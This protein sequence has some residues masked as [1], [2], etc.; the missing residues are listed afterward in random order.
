MVLAVTEPTLSGLHDLER[1]VNLAEHFRVRALA[2]V[3]KF[4]LNAEMTERIEEYARGRGVGVMS[5][6]PYDTSVTQA[7]LAGKSVVENG[8]GPAARAIRTLWKE[9]NKAMDGNEE[10]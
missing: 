10:G 2:C 3:N 6:V 8:D 1:V 9:V 7:Q 4:D 5:R